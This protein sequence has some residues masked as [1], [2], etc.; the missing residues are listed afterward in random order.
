MY[1]FIYKKTMD[2]LI[3]SIFS[4]FFLL[5]FLL[6]SIEL[7]F[8]FFSWDLGFTLCLENKQRALYFSYE[9]KGLQPRG[10]DTFI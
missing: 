5:L 1:G 8:E 9:A 3:Y 4:P 2:I 7:F 6:I 10:G